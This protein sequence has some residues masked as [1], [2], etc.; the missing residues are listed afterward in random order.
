MYCDE[1]D[2]QPTY[3]ATEADNFVGVATQCS[4]SEGTGGKQGRTGTP[5]GLAKEE[6]VVDLQA[7]ISAKEV[8]EED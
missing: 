8:P 3:F 5:G 2:P 6:G 7:S 4:G 1:V